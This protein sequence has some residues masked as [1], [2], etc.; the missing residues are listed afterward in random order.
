AAVN[1]LVSMNWPG[2]V[3]QLEAVVRRAAALAAGSVIDR[4]H[5][6]SQAQ[7]VVTPSA[8]APTSQASRETPEDG[9]LTE[10]SIRPFEEEEQ[11]L[12]SRALRATKGNVRRAAQLLGIGRATLYRK[13]QQYRLRLQ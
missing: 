5:L 8:A 6:L 9:E 4:E 7:P 2:N 1:L 3:A 11:E 13:I 12:L 10:A